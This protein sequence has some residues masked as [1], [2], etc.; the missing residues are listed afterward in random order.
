MFRVVH[1]LILPQTVAH[2]VRRSGLKK[3]L[4]VVMVSLMAVVVVLRVNIMAR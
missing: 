1:P 4:M 2:P 3:V